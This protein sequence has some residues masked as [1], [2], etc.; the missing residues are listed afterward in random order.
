MSKKHLYIIFGSVIIV[1]LAFYFIQSNLVSKK[2]DGY[3]QENL[4]ENISLTYDNIK[5]NLISGNVTLENATLHVKDQGAKIYISEFKAKGFSYQKIIT[6]D[7]LQLEKVS[8]ENMRVFIDKSQKIPVQK[9]N[10]K[11]KN[12]ILKLNKLEL[13]LS[14]LEVKDENGLMKASMDATLFSLNNLIIQTVPAQDQNYLKY[15]LTKVA[16]DSLHLPLS[17]FQTLSIGHLVIDSTS[18]DLTDTQLTLKDKGIDVKFKKLALDGTL[19]NNLIDKDSL[20]FENCVLSQGTIE[21]NNAKKQTKA[22][23]DSLNRANKFIGIK[24][25]KIE[26][27][28]F[29]FLNKKG[30]LTLDFSKTNALF[31]DLEILTNPSDSE[32]ALTYNFISLN[33][34]DIKYPMNMHTLTAKNININSKEILVNNLEINP[35]YSREVFQTKL[36]EER[37]MNTLKLPSLKIIDY[38]Y[39]IDTNSPYLLASQV[40]LNEPNLNVYRNKYPKN[41]TG[42]KPL[43][44]EMLREMNFE[45]GI[46]R[47]DI[48]NGEITYEEQQSFNRPSGKL[49]FADINGKVHDLYNK[50]LGNDKV[51][52]DASLMFMGHAPTHVLWNFHVLQ[53]ADQFYFEGVINDLKGSSLDNFLAANMKAKIDGTVEKTTF[54]FSG[55]D[56]GA[57][58]KMVM[59]YDN[60]EVEILNNEHKKKGFWSVIAN[61]F[62]KREKIIDDDSYQIVQVERDQKKSFFNLLWLFLK[63]GLKQNMVKFQTND[64]SK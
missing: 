38:D 8:F 61:F 1:A 20:V 51:T 42:R 6:T 46:K 57:K 53:P 58:G 19:L 63:Q 27:S 5:S 62:V 41:Q 31:S 54:H 12:T 3:I 55:A 43:Y 49:L 13:G 28:D 18:L 25:L 29:T 16:T 14:H 47:I 50:R 33:A 64:S 22:T 17:E 7:T 56:W 37:D 44:S 21:I 60:V 48:E 26:D 30:K 45:L 34:A 9:S 24:N 40:I 2:L 4:P 15:K 52:L 32:N 36:K 39:S 11:S 23:K 10:K 35:N 59:D